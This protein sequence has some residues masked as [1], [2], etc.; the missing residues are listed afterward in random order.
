MH[1]RSSAAAIAAAQSPIFNSQGKQADRRLIL[2]EEGEEEDGDFK[3]NPWLCAA[4]FLGKCLV[5][6][7]ILLFVYFWFC[8]LGLI[9]FR[10]G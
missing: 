9:A 1:R 4:E 6:E 8:F 5:L 10:A 7:F 3:L 2:E